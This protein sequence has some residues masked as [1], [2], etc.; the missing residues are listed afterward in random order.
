MDEQGGPSA[1]GDRQA[2]AGELFDHHAEEVYRCVLGWTLDR[3]SALDLTTRVLRTAVDR[4]EQILE[5]TDAAGLEMRVFAL[6]RAAVTRWQTAAKRREAAPV[7]PE[8]SMALFDALG[9]LDDNQREALILCELVGFDTEHVGRLLGCDQSVVEE[10]RRQ[11]S[12]TLWRKLD[13]APEVA[14][15]STWD[16]LTVGV[17][18]R[19]A[20][21]QWLTPADGTALAY[22]REQLLGEA[23]VGVPAK[24]PER[25]AA[26]PTPARDRSDR[27]DGGSGA[28]TGA[29]AVAGASMG[30]AGGAEGARGAKGAAA[31]AEA[32]PRDAGGAPAVGPPPPPKPFAERGSK[33]SRAAAVKAAAAAAAAKAGGPAA[34]VLSPPSA[35]SD[36]SMPPAPSAPP[37]PSPPLRPGP[38]TGPGG[39]PVTG[40][41]ARRPAGPPQ[42]GAPPT[43]PAAAAAATAG[44]A[45]APTSGKPAQQRGGQ[46]PQPPQSAPRPKDPAGA[47]QGGKDSKDT[48]GPKDSK[49][50]DAAAVAGTERKG[51]RQRALALLGTATRERWMAL[52]IAALAAAG[53]GVLAALTMGGAVGSTPQCPDGS[54]CL[55][56]T[57][58]DGVAGVPPMR[59][60]PSGN[61]IPTTTAG[62]PAP[63]FPNFTAPGARTTTTG[64]DGLPTTLRPPVTTVK[65]PVTTRR[66]PTTTL[67]PTTPSTTPTTTAPPT[68]APPTTA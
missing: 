24:A 10:L 13:G 60:D 12:E 64:P 27:A 15:V 59:T 62:G 55:V 35:P 65:P 37:A 31:A 51:L 23:P 46:P 43:R 33:R 2:F 52:G 53:I 66:V 38:R 26:K 41:E 40:D 3:S 14:A 22:L 56:S 6:A 19:R 67:P 57:T 18:L 28:A 8:E 29:A 7:V 61:T 17:A 49:G 4:R 30:D 20:A 16:R 25:G 11:A 58:L 42:K 45:V 9:E 5:G 21:A 48:K 63:G 36:P 1:V 47:A 68:T 54:G 44:A 32:S 50:A 34:A 39:P